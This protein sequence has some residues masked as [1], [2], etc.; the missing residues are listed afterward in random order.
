M[1]RNL[2]LFRF[3]PQVAANLNDL[4]TKLDDYR[5]RP[6]GSLEMKTRGFVPPVDT[7]PMGRLSQ[8]VGIYTKIV[9][10]GED[11]LLPPGVVKD[12]VQRRVQAIAETQGRKLSGSERKRIHEDVLT[13][14]LPRAFVKSSRVAAY[15]DTDAGW[16]VVDTASRKVAEVEVTQ[17][18]E[19][20]GSFPAV[21]LVPEEGPRVTMTSWLATGKLPTGLALGNECELRDLSS[22]AGARW[23]GKNADLESEEVGE[24]LRNGMQVFSLGLI[25]EN[26]ISFVLSEDLVIHKVRL[27]DEVLDEQGD[28]EQ[29]LDSDFILMT[30]ELGRLLVRLE[31]IF[32]LPRPN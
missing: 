8:T 29:S 28:N 18:R 30:L 15:V 19:A 7:D 25:F 11:K 24:H 4:D 31:S 1:F 14:L 20:L 23:K 17:L 22:T 21:P 12:E 3:S 27:M 26:R 6:C 9:V 5:L 16:L 32:K 10:G 13:E 2:S